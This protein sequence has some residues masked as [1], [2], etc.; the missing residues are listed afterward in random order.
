[1]VWMH[2]LNTQ[3][4]KALRQILKDPPPADEMVR[5]FLDAFYHFEALLR[6]VEN[7]YRCRP[8]AKTS[9]TDHRSLDIA[10]ARRSLKHFNIKI[11]ESTLTLLLSSELKKRNSRSARNLRNAIAHNWSQADRKE[12]IDRHQQLME[13]LNTAINWFNLTIQQR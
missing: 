3:Q 9:G 8:G 11:S 1:M 10:V 2:E 13:A 5:S 6:K 12:V 4:R 7:Y